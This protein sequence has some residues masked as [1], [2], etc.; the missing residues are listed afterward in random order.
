MA[1][2][3]NNLCWPKGMPLILW[4]LVVLEALNMWSKVEVNRNYGSWVAKAMV[5]DNM[6]TKIWKASGKRKL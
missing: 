6:K 4:P 5:L 2:A 1:S 3:V